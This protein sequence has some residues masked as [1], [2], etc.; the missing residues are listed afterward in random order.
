MEQSAM[1][2]SLA[3]FEQSLSHFPDHPTAVVGLSNILLD[4]Y[5]GTLS[6]ESGKSSLPGVVGH[7]PIS[8]PVPTVT[9]TSAQ[10]PVELQQPARP[11]HL[12]QQQTG[13][14]IDPTPADLNLLAARDRAYMLLSTL[15]K[16]GEGWDNA[17]AWFVLARAYEL[18]GQLDKS[19]ECLWWV[20]QLEDTRPIRHWRCV[21]GGIV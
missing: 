1:H 3:A 16:L 13:R 18:S 8:Q 6:A 11:S 2:D 7:S 21:R 19:R 9:S 10:Q 17:D 20:V 14:Q 15:T 12:E 4:I 5:E